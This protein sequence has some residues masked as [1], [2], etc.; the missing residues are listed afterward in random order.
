MGNTACAN[1]LAGTFASNTGLSASTPCRTG[2]FCNVGN[3]V[4]GAG[5]I[6]LICGE[7]KITLGAGTSIASCVNPPNT[8]TYISTP[9]IQGTILDGYYSTTLGEFN[10]IPTAYGLVC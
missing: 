4:T 9:S 6:E 5:A 10:P 3:V 1:T 2:Y 7:G 8:A